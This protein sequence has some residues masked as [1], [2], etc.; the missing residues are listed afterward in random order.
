[1]RTCSADFRLTLSSLNSHRSVVC[2]S[3]RSVNVHVCVI[4]CNNLYDIL[5]YKPTHLG[6]A[7]LTAG[8]QPED[9]HFLYDELK[10]SE[11]N[12]LCLADRITV[13]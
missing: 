9:A 8:L 13:V 4:K 10:Y 7:A 3:L 2:V 12:N 6:R 5:E 11:F 1:M